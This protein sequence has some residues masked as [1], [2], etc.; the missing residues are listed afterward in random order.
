LVRRRISLPGLFAVLLALMV[1]LGLGA[2][3]P[4][5]DPVAQAAALCHP[6]G[7]PGPAPTHP[8]DCVVCPLCIV[9]HAA[10]AGLVASQEAV[11]PPSRVVARRVA[12]LPPSTAPPLAQRPPSQPRAPPAYS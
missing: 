10:P 2:A 5:L 8:A 4:R 11:L 1:Q 9:L 7:A 12:L 3:V 6:G